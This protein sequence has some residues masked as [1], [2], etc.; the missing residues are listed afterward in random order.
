MLS[1]PVFGF[2][3]IDLLFLSGVAFSLLEKSPALLEEIVSS[4]VF[5]TVYEVVFI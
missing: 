2:C 5:V 3:L 4:G 1:A